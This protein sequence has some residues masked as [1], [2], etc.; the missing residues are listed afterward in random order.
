MYNIITKQDYIKAAEKFLEPVRD[1]LKRGGARPVYGS[2]SAWY[3]DRSVYCEAFAR[4]LWAL[5]PIWHSGGGDAELKE[6]YRRG[7]AEGTDPDSD[8]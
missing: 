3:D 4:P 2:A 5:A 8:M 7:I 6:L 1:A